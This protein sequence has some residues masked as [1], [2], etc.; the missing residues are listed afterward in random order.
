MR[1][2]ANYLGNGE[3]E[4][5]VWSPLLDSVTV[6]I[7]TPEQQLIPLKPTSEGY[8]QTKVNDVYPDTLYRYVLNGQDTFADP[9]SQYQPEGVHGPSQIVDH[10]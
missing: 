6:Q 5:T 10:Q 3:C 7:L 4:F 2:G 1:I 9:A 8:W